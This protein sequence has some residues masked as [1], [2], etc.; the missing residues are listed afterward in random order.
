MDYRN[1]GRAGL[2]V[3]EICLGT[4]TMGNGADQAEASRMVD[5]AMAAG[6]NFFDTANAYV[7]GT[8]E[9]MLGVA[10]KGKRHDAIVATKFFNPMGHRP[11]DS[12]MSRLHIKQQIEGSLKRLQT[13]Y[14]DIY[15]IHHV[16]HQ[17]PLE[18]MLRALDDLVRQGK[19]LYTACSN[20]EAWRLMEA[21]WLSDTRGWERFACYQPQYSL[22]LLYTSD[23][24]DE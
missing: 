13:D 19:I 16:D 11:N 5:A 24:A 14:L 15:Y 4:M 17:T 22:C 3:S 2:K 18:E 21:L 10:L 8:S 12:G 6:V 7:G 9:T 20:F 23:A 1:L